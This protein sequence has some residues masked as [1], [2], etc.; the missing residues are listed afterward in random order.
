MADAV[1]EATEK[2]T[3]SLEARALVRAA[4]SHAATESAA[5]VDLAYEMGGAT[6]IYEKS[7]LQ[8]AKRDVHVATQH[9]MVAPVAATLAGRVLLG[10]ESDTST[11]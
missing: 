9:I 3:A 1:R 6:S 10:L 8:R 7:P 4:A 2:G 11:L 5:A